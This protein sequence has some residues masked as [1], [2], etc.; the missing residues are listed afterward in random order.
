MG[1][2]TGRPRPEERLDVFVRA[3]DDDEAFTTVRADVDEDEDEVEDDD[4]D[5]AFLDLRGRLVRLVPRGRRG[6]NE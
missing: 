6:A 3:G 1:R 4:V 2:A 5:P